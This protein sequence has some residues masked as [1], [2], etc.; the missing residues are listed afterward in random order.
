M[1]R[2]KVVLNGQARVYEDGRVFKIKPD[3]REVEVQAKKAKYKAR[4]A[5]LTFRTK[6]GKFKKIYIHRLV[7]QTF[8]PVE[9]PETMHVHHKDRNPRNNRVDNL[10]WLEP[11]I[12]AGVEKAAKPLTFKKGLKCPQCGAPLSDNHYE[13]RLCDRCKKENAI[14]SKFQKRAQA[15]AGKIPLSALKDLPPKR[16]EIVIAWLAGYTYQAIG[17]KYGGIS[18]QSVHQTISRVLN[19]AN[20]KIA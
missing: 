16:R 14:R 19:N 8:I 4:Y 2:S 1:V 7:A 12:H 5:S 20:K 11:R 6:T 18:R 3:G 17:K 10:V 9:N 15:R 13:S